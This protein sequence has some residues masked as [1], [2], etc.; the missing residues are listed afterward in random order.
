[1]DRP[2]A[3][4]RRIRS[5]SPAY[6][7]SEGT[8]FNGDGR[9]RQK[10]TLACTRCKKRKVGENCTPSWRCWQ[11][12]R[13]ATSR[14][15][16]LSSLR[17][18]SAMALRPLVDHAQ[19]SELPASGRMLPPTGA[20]VE[21]RAQLWPSH[22]R[23]CAPPPI[24]YSREPAPPKPP[25]SIFPPLPPLPYPSPTLHNPS[26]QFRRRL[27]RLSSVQKQRLQSSIKIRLV[28]ITF[29]TCYLAHLREA[30]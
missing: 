29:G 7:D 27:R 6:K 17:R 24:R 14:E 4:Y 10:V 5:R 12:C 28:F 22:H 8:P 9:V 2:L 16:T 11:R 1:M 18:A 21:E 25:F 15:L 30:S 19:E 23:R 20:S 3:G 13:G 26:A